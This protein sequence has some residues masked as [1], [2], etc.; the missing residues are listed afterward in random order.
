MSVLLDGLRGVAAL[1]VLI[2]HAGQIGLLGQRWP[3]SDL[4]QHSAVLVF[5]VMSGLLVHESATRENAT[6]RSFAVARATRVLPV[7]ILALAL[8]GALSVALS[9][10]ISPTLTPAAAPVTIQGA[11]G[12]SF[13]LTSLL[14]LNERTGGSEPV[15]NPPYWS[16]CYEVWFYVLYGVA[17][18]TRGR[19]RIAGLIAAAAVADGLILLLLPCWLVGVW[20]GA[21]GRELKPRRPRLLLASASLAFAALSWSEL[22]HQVRDLLTHLGVDTAQLRFSTYCL[23]DVVAAAAV[24]IGLVAA[25]SLRPNVTRWTGVMRW[26]ARSSFTLYLT[27]WPLLIAAVVIVPPTS[28]WLRASLALLVPLAFAQIV[29]PLVE[30]RATAALRALVR[31]DRRA[32]TP[33]LAATLAHP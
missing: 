18:F 19:F 12:A 10:A 4:L 33:S 31:P 16:L 22:P 28:P 13:L 14:F 26:S 7:A 23:T 11:T 6:L 9:G 27:H 29:A 2:G 20:V 15:F 32:S 5:F 8:T 17:R 30:R 25:R 24:A 3:F 21:R 1:I